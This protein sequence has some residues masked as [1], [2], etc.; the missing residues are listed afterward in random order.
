MSPEP[1]PPGYL[2][3]DFD[4]VLHPLDTPALGANGQLLDNPDLF[5]WLPIL[6]D[7]LAPHPTVKIIVSSD[8]RRLFDDDALT[9]L[10]GPLGP[11]FAGITETIDRNRA[12]EI[13][14]DATRRGIENWIALDDH[15]TVRIAAAQDPRYIWLR[16]TLG[17]SE[18]TAQQQ[19]QRALKKLLSK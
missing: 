10:L 1:P 11:R 4:G 18:P 8:W 14:H 15:D 2:Y 12:N 3:L 9:R 16:E 17:L 6:A 5:C 7:L 13:L 19:L